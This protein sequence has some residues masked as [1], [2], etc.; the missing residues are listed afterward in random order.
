MRAIRFLPGLVCAL[1]LACW[2][3][4]ARPDS[5]EYAVKAAY[6]TKFVP[7]IE[8][9]DTA[10]ASPTS[11]ITICVLG[12]DPFAGKLEQVAG[13]A[14]SGERGILVRH[15]AAADASC[16]VVFLGAPDSPTTDAVLQ[17]LKGK[18]VVTV[19]DSSVKARGVIS[20]VLAD[21]HVRFDIDDGAAAQDGIKISSKLLGLAHAVH[22]RGQP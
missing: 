2:S 4:P 17:E 13:T 6:L 22:Q 20:F 12:D 11:P 3:A 18:P 16:Q 1:G 5:L 10:F 21:N 9:P 15:P 19:T 7:F 8:W 14:R